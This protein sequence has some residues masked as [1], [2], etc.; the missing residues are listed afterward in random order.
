[1]DE[2]NNQTKFSFLFIQ[3][4]PFTLHD[5]E[6][7]TLLT[8]SHIRNLPKKKSPKAS[9]SKRRPLDSNHN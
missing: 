6:A 1:M 7:D 4:A 5:R 3:Q 2:K 9:R 8:L